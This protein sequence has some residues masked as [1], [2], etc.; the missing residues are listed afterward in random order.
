MKIAVIGSGITGLGA[1]WLL[2]QRYD[3]TLYEKEAQAGGH[4]NTVIARWPECPEGVAVDTGFIVYN[5]PTYPN[6]TAF[7][8]RL[9]VPTQGSDMS[10]AFSIDQGAC[11]YSCHDF[12]GLFAQARNFFDPR[13]LSMLAEIP[14]FWREGQAQLKAGGDE[15]LRAWLGR[16]GFSDRFIREHLA[17]AGGAIWSATPDALLDFPAVSFL[18]FFE[19]HGLLR[20]GARI[21][22][23]TV[24]GGSR[25]YVDTVI[26]DARFRLRLS[27]P[28]LRVER[29]AESSRV[30]TADGIELYDQIVFAC[31]ADTALALTAAPTAAERAVLSPFTFQENRAVLHRDTR[32]M[33]KARRAWASWNCLL[34]RRTNGQD[35]MAVTYWM[36]RLQDLPKE[37]PLFVTLNPLRPVDER[38]V[39]SEY[40]YAHPQFSTATLRAQKA[41]AD[42]QGQ[43]GFWFCGAWMGYGF[44]EDGLSSGLAVAEALGV[45]RPW[46][47]Q[48]VS[49]AY[50]NSLPKIGQRR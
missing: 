19:N 42:V 7:F 44:H 41:M 40:A 28:I 20:G 38:L 37:W 13:F 31:H 15:S 18:R 34:E 29:E 36:N 3:V 24:A 27:S 22:W 50:A 35:A 2:A 25:R 16:L 14:R 21:P 23:R 12:S 1:A 33:P 9:N 8:E 4:A 43:N 39:I 46:A 48:Q 26:K 49:P 32:H 47:G 5:E 17:P 6:L 11:E 45:P 30:H 10:L